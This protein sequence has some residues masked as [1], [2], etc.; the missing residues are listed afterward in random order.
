M[1]KNILRVVFGF[2]GVIGWCVESVAV[3][4]PVPRQPGVVAA[5]FPS[6][7]QDA[8]FTERVQNKAIGYEPF[9]DITVFEALKIEKQ[10]LENYIS[11]LETVAQHDLNTMSAQQYCDKYPLDAEHCV[12][13]PGIVAQVESI[14]SV[15]GPA[16]KPDDGVGD[17]VAGQKIH[18]GPCTPPARSNH[19]SN[20]ILTTGQYQSVD[21]AF[22]K[23][24][25]TI[26]RK[27]GGCVND[28]DDRGGYTC[29]GVSSNANPEVDFTN[30]TR[31]DAENIAYKKYYTRYNIDALPD[32]IRPEVMHAAWGAG[33][34]T[35]IN[36]LKRKLNLPADGKIDDATVTAAENYPGDLRA[37]YLDEMV[38]YY[39]KC[40]QNGNNK[41]FL[42]GWLNSV[43]LY[44]ENGCHTPTD[45]PIYR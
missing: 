6:T 20:K 27:E 38:K 7:A 29:Y 5:T 35:G 8:T 17:V 37:E 23:T 34:V 26:F 36:M 1:I 43:R 11:S 28:P 10:E 19:F 42:K 13:T 4:F 22:E 32:Y 45:N 18:D 30:F 25:I 14:A 31:G 16:V 24:M 39:K 15:P 2:F 44:R 3:P 12:V 40:A 9:K 33:P 21:P 41:K